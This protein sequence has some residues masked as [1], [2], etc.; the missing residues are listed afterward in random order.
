M[1]TELIVRRCF[2]VLFAMLTMGLWAQGDIANVGVIKNNQGIV[3]DVN[4]A[5]RVLKGGL[6]AKAEVSQITIEYSPGDGKYYLIGKISNDPVSGKA[7]QLNPTPDGGGVFAANGP[8]VTITC[9]GTLCSS[10]LPD[11]KRW[12]PRCVCYDSSPPAGMSCSMTSS[13]AI[14]F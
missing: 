4:E 14:G 11:I 1:K 10:C 3:T 2:T 5:T 12:R 13:A 8:G 9:T 7:V 6:S